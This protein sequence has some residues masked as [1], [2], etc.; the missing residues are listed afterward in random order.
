MLLETPTSTRSQPRIDEILSGQEFVSSFSGRH[1][2]AIGG[3]SA[4][5]L[6]ALN[7][8]RRIFEKESEGLHGR[9]MLNGLMCREACEDI[10]SICF[11]WST[12]AHLDVE[13]IYAAPI[14]KRTLKHIWSEFN[15]PQF[16]HFRAAIQR[17]VD[18]SAT[19]SSA[20]MVIT[21]PPEIISVLKIPVNETPIFVIFDSH[22]RD[23]HPDGAGFIF[24][25]SIDATALYLHELLR[26]DANL[27]GD[28]SLQ[29]QAQ[30]LANFSAHAYVSQPGLT[31]EDMQTMVV[32]S[33]LAT[34]DL[35]AQVQVLRESQTELQE[36]KAQLQKEKEQLQ[37]ELSRLRSET[38][39]LRD[40]LQVERDRRMAMETQRKQKSSSNSFSLLSSSSSYISSLVNPKPSSSP[41]STKKHAS[42]SSNS[43]PSTSTCDHDSRPF[44]DSSS[45]FPSLPS[46]SPHQSSA[47]ADGSGASTSQSKEVIGDTDFSSKKRKHDSSRRAGK[48]PSRTDDYSRA[49]DYAPV[50]PQNMDYDQNAGILDQDDE[51]LAYALR[52]QREFEEENYQLIVQGKALQANAQATFKCSVCMDECPEDSIARVEPCRHAFC[53][54]CARQYV[55]VKI[56]EHCFPIICPECATQKDKLSEGVIDSFLLQQLGIEEK[57]YAIYEEMELS[58]FSV[59]LHCRK[60]NNTTFVDK[61][62]HQEEKIIHCPLPGCAHIWCKT[63]SK[64]IDIAPGEP[65]HS[66]DG[67]SELTH[68]MGQK[69]WKYCPGCKTPAEKTEGCQHMTCPASGCNTHFCY[70]CGAQIIKSINKREIQAALGSH[71]RKC[72]LFNYN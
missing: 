72:Q 47:A 13:D 67:S 70:A 69:G 63:C 64:T 39:Q 51:S 43:M 71:Y 66:C 37:T 56:K 15:I 10:L 45:H 36:D 40:R 46:S 52:L 60:C 7:C 61:R 35:G 9:D 5:G 58:A 28:T 25:S 11:K 12:T 48:L 16:D 57:L 19:T 6:V 38:Y 20:A 14:F 23:K 2:Y 55:S 49:D 27:V 30:L 18:T 59:L 24:N 21:R 50:I 32:E 4:C 3:V 62:E 33:S 29:W 1:Q 42:A 31:P 54:D 26:F 65:P 68:L 8:A 53:R 34:L 17:L 22:P 44:F 41:T